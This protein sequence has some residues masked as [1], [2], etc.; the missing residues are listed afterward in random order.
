MYHW[1]ELVVHHKVHTRK[2]YDFASRHIAR[3][4]LAAP[5][6]NPSEEDYR[7]WCVYRRIGGVGLAC[8]WAGTTW[9]GMPG[10]KSRERQATLARLMEQGSVCE[11]HVEGIDRPCYVRSQDWERFDAR[12]E[13]GG[14]PPQAAILAP[15]DNLLWDRRLV[16]ELFGFAYRWEVYKPVAEREYGYY[17]LPILYGDRFV[18]RFE[19]GRD[20]DSG[21]LIVKQW[22]WEPDV[23]P[24]AEMQSALSRCFQRFLGYLGSEELWMDAGTA[25][26]TGMAWAVTVDP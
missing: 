6:P 11:V 3:E 18:A 17:V 20:K 23:T 22:W 5:D 19:P 2:V 24:T 13:T 14:Q 21:A 12:S 16:E 15:L 9:L 7:D 4:L 1:G 26:S 25:G 10:R 8:G